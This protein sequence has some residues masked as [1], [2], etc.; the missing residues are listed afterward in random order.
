MWGRPGRALKDVAQ[1]LRTGWGSSARAAVTVLAAASAILVGALAVWPATGQAAGVPTPHFTEIW[2]RT[3]AHQFNLSDP[4][5]AEFGGR[6]AV[7]VGDTGGDLDAD[8]LND[9]G[10]VPGWPVRT[11]AALYKC[12]KTGK[13]PYVSLGISGPISADLASAGSDDIF[14][15][16]GGGA[17]A[18]GESEPDFEAFTPSGARIYDTDPVVETTATQV[19]LDGDGSGPGLS[20]VALADIGGQLDGF[21]GGS[22]GHELY[23]INAS[24]GS[25][26]FNYV[27]G[28][29]VNGTP[30][31]GSVGHTEPNLVY[32]VGDA[33]YSSSYQGSF[34]GAYLRILEPN[35]QEV[36]SAHLQNPNPHDNYQGGSWVTSPVLADFGG[37]P[38]VVVGQGDRS[39]FSTH[40]MAYNTACQEI[41]ESPSLAGP[42][43]YSPVAADI[44]GNGVPSVIEETENDKDN[45]VIYE[46]NG[47]NGSIIRQSTLAGCTGISRFTTSQSVVTADL[48]GEAYQ[49]MIAP[50]GSCGYAVLD[51][52]TLH[53]VRTSAKKRYLTP[54][55]AGSKLKSSDNTALVTQTSTDHGTL[56]ITVAGIGVK[57]HSKGCV[58]SWAVRGVN[59]KPAAL[60]VS[61]WPEFHRDQRLTGFEETSLRRFT[62]RD[63]LGPGQELTQGQELTSANGEYTA[64]MQSDGN[65][66]V[67][68]HGKALWQTETYKRPSVEEGRRIVMQ[69]DGNLAI[70]DRKD[71]PVWDSHTDGAGRPTELVMQ[72]DGNLALY[73]GPEGGNISYAVSALWSSGS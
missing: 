55:C 6:E 61:G 50:A 41:W 10:T 24:T 1:E 30:A 56:V 17:P 54:E 57:A 65:F 4:V 47:S 68:Q 21:S 35:G 58:V 45:P 11:R 29:T 39:R 14:A 22:T 27:N 31:V 46:I 18:N 49:D 26:I 15:Q 44:T 34:A 52:H 16:I 33:T 40:V 62:K 28:D 20:G 38:L 72:D 19:A 13:C 8:W 73:D 48:T 37:V 67:Y 59:N 36:C 32:S 23:G 66:A 25:G 53:L 70:Y 64:V 51:G 60:G 69:T 3:V 12:P 43:N 9:G 2:N 71:Q 7:V 63:V 42:T 5:E